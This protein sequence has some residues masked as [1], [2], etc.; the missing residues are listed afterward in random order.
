MEGII[1]IG[2][3][4]R[5]ESL[6]TAV[7]RPGR[8]DKLLN[9]PLPD[10]KGR[11]KIFDAYLSKVKTDGRIDANTLSSITI[12]FTGA[13]IQN[14][15]NQA[16]VNAV[17]ENRTK[18]T[19]KDLQNGLTDVIMGVKRPLLLEGHEKFLTAIHEGGHA[20]TAFF[21]PGAGTI[22]QATILPRG[23]SLGHVQ[24]EFSINRSE[25]MAKL[26]VSFGGRVAEELFFGLDKTTTG[27]SSDLENCRRLAHEIV[28]ANGFTELGF[29]G[30]DQ[31]KMGPKTQESLDQEIAKILKESYDRVTALLTEHKED[32][33]YLA[34]TLIQQETL[35]GGNI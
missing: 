21:T 13:D 23:Q 7:L 33:W 2:A 4:N 24:T 22:F 16:A 20:V 10:R 32:V 6:D 15:V 18:V 25:L 14:V 9:V 29:M 31:S 35:T 1:F 3:T 12:G 34:H 5:M 11:K 19:T 30:T 28:L 26:D 17:R 27:A 8:I